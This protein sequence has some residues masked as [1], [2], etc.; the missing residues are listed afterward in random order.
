MKYSS[1]WQ[2]QKNCFTIIWP[3][4]ESKSFQ[5]AH[6]FLVI[7]NGTWF[8]SV[9]GYI[10]LLP[11]IPKTFNVDLYPFMYFYK[12]SGNFCSGGIV[13][14]YVK[15]CWGGNSFEILSLVSQRYGYYDVV[16]SWHRFVSLIC[17][18]TTY[19]LSGYLWHATIP[20]MKFHFSV[21][22]W[23]DHNKLCAWLIVLTLELA[24]FTSIQISIF[25]YGFFF[26]ARKR[27]AV[28]CDDELLR[29]SLVRLFP[30]RN[31]RNKAIAICE[32]N[33]SSIA[34]QLQAP[35][36][37]CDFCLQA[38]CIISSDFKPNRR[39]DA[40]MTNDTKRCKD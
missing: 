40:C 19:D 35:E 5:I 38:P 21:T 23:D 36:T 7:T 10:I 4:W 14:D 3:F 25:K 11:A 37:T 31:K 12:R 39:C 33:N 15:C 32:N 22:I 29:P 18:L 9:E 20:F 30:Q 34:A 27:F 2:K 28:P 17:I 24:P 13:Y 8:P 16:S 26:T 6:F 1:Q